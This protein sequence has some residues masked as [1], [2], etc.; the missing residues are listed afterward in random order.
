MF[1][2]STTSYTTDSKTNFENTTG[3]IKITCSPTYPMIA[4]DDLYDLELIELKQ[5][6]KLFENLTLTQRKQFLASLIE[7]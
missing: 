2:N 7:T 6:S 3:N 4:K 1:E 5:I